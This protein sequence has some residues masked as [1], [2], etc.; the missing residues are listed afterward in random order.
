MTDTQKTVPPTHPHADR[1][2]K[3]LHVPGTPEQVTAS[4]FNERPK[5]R[6]KWRYLHSGREQ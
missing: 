4:L 3:P 6:D 1:H 5:S 2:A